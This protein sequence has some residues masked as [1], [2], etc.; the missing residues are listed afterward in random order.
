MGTKASVEKVEY[1]LLYF[2]GMQNGGF[3]I[4]SPR[5]VLK[6]SNDP[7]LNDWGINWSGIQEHDGW[8]EGNILGLNQG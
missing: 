6:R 5:A 7:I 2:T 4:L 1:F 3:V 8:A